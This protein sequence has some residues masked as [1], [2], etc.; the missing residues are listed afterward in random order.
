MRPA[1]VNCASATSR[2]T[3][4]SDSRDDSN[5]GSDLRTQRPEAI[6]PSMNVLALITRCSRPLAAIS[7]L[8]AIALVVFAVAPVQA[9]DPVLTRDVPELERLPDGLFG[10]PL[11]VETD[12]KDEKNPDLTT[13]TVGHLRV[14]VVFGFIIHAEFTANSSDT[15]MLLFPRT[16]P[17]DPELRLT[18]RHERAFLMLSGYFW[19]TRAARGRFEGVLAGRRAAGFWAMRRL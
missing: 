1:S 7:R 16:T 17:D 13:A 8:V 10:G 15:P 11:W 6:L 9:N 12:S 19:D 2:T 3:T 18:G 14:Q 4:D 5:C